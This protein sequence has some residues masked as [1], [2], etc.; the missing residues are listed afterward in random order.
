M[1]LKE[2]KQIVDLMSKNGLSEFQLEKDKFKIHLKKQGS[3]QV[4]VIT[5]PAPAAA[6][7][8]AL[9]S[10]AAPGLPSL[11]AAP[12]PAAEAPVADELPTI[13]SPMV[14]TFYQSPSPESP[15]YIKVGDS[16]T[17]DSVVCIVEAMK[18]MNEI[19]AEMKGT[20]VEILAENGKPVEFGKPLFKVRPS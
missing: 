8:A 11:P 3:E 5:T 1:E 14:G 6:A 16:V 18:V 7:P 20:I 13:N 19:K 17:E 12:A 4:Q 2:I 10:A 15:A 9:P